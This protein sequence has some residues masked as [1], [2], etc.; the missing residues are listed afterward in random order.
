MRRKSII[1]AALLTFLSPGMLL[2][3][4]GG[5]VL[6]AET[7][8]TKSSAGKWKREYDGWTYTDASGKAVTSK[9]KEIDGKWYFFNKG[10]IMESNAYRNGYYLTNG[11]TWDGKPD[12]WIQR[13][14]R[15]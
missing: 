4:M 8:T 5:A 6:A 15:T 10:S 2:S 7:G 1:T 9:W 12:G 3:D 14:P 13:Q 11:G